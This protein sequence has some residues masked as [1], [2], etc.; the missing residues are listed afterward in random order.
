MNDELMTIQDIAD[1]FRCNYRTAR[2][3]KTKLVGF[4]DRAP[5]SSV[6]IPLW[7]RT[8]VQCFLHAKSAKTR[9]NPASAR[10]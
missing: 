9:T 1:L 8:D 2:D 3:V 7:L 4:P 6:R 5:G 10:I